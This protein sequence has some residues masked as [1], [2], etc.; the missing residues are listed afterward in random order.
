MNNRY[1]FKDSKGSNYTTDDLIKTLKSVKADQ[2]E[3]LFVHTDLNFGL[4]NPLMKRKEYFEMMFECLKQLNVGTL[5]FPAFSYSFCNNED[6]DVRN[7]KTSMGALIEYIR[8]N[9]DVTRSVDPLL[10]IIT[11]GSRK[12]LFNVPLGNNSLGIGS[13]FD[14]LHNTE[15]VKF[16]FFGAAFE[17]YFTYVH[18]VEKMLNV[19]YRYDQAFTGNIIDYNG[20]IYQDTHYIHTRCKGAKLKNFFYMKQELIEEKK[21]LVE[22]IGDSEIACISEKDAY[23]AITKRI[24][25]DKYSFVEPFKPDELVN[26][27]TFGKNGE[28]VTHC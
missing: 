3:I 17:E 13:S 4:P 1:L 2:C 11:Y 27:Y 23:N 20:N 16:L 22:S 5:M 24:L 25:N 6:F 8:K 9:K 19:S 12:D 18:Y 15:G 21:L 28:R 14:I 10:S 7:T 26:E